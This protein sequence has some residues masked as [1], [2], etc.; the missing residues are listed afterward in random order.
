MIWAGKIDSLLI[1]TLLKGATD[2]T[3]AAVNVQMMN[4]GSVGKEGREPLSEF[5]L[6]HNSPVE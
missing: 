5:L 4:E 6:P 1:A 3:T 2:L